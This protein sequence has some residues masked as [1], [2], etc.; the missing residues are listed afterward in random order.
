[1]NKKRQG[2]IAR[3]IVKDKMPKNGINDQDLGN[4]AKYI[5]CISVEELRQFFKNLE[6]SQLNEREGQI[7]SYIIEHKLYKGGLPGDGFNRELGN[8]SKRQGVDIEELRQFF[9]AIL[10]KFLART[11]GR[12][13]ITLNVGKW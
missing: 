13:S 10:P 2:E 12:K 3:L 7:A 5:Q 8:L 9:E 4:M 6:V 1:M 11:L